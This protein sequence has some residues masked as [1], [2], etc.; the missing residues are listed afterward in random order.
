[1]TTGVIIYEKD[2]YI[3]RT[4]TERL[5]SKMPDSYIMDGNDEESLRPLVG[6]C[7]EY[8]VIYDQRQYGKNAF[9][10]KANTF[11]LFENG[12][13]DCRKIIQPIRINP[14]GR[15]FTKES[16][17]ITLLLPFVYISEREEFIRSRLQPLKDSDV[18]LRFDLIS[19]VNSLPKYGESLTELLRNVSKKKF[20]AVD[21]LDYCAL[22]ERGFFTP[23][24]L[25]VKDDINSH[26]ISEYKNLITKTKE[27]TDDKDK[28]A[29]A[30]VVAEGLNNNAVYGIA[31]LC[32]RVMLLLPDRTSQDRPGMCEFIAGLSRACNGKDIEIETVIN[33]ED[34]EPAV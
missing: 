23:G 19:R 15:K 2:K 12:I 27:I 24:C 10:G 7:D 1:M 3:L 32:D 21:I 22:D 30:L 33:E 26:P 14:S 6:L 5:R 20:E 25:S 31:G 16:S 34:Y 11:P 18:C 28:N 17:G 8:I 9:S 13:I 4:L 29:S